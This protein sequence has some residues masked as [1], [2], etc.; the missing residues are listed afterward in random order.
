MQDMK[1]APSGNVNGRLLNMLAKYFSIIR[2]YLLAVFLQRRCTILPPEH[3][4]RTNLLNIIGRNPLM[5]I[6]FIANQD[7]TPML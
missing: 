5:M 1:I 3:A 2:N 6:R 4:S 7:L